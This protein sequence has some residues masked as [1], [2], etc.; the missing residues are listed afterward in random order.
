MKKEYDIAVDHIV[1][2]NLFNS[3]A[4]MVIPALIAPGLVLSAVFRRDYP[5]MMLFFTFGLWFLL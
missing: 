1:G 4:V 5:V 2:S 3:L